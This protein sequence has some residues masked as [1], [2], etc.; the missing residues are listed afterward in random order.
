MPSR[1]RLHL[2]GIL[3]MRFRMRMEDEL[4]AV[5]LLRDARDAMRRVDQPLE[6]CLV[7]ARAGKLLAGEE[8][9]VGLVDE[10]QELRV[11]LVEDRPPAAEL[12]LDVRP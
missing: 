3:D 5:I 12:A 6:A 10:D 2:V 8:V 4:Q 7:Q 11:E 9:R 1:K